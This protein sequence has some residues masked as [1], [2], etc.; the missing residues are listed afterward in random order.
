[1]DFYALDKPLIQCDYGFLVSVP[2]F[3]SISVN[4]PVI[5]LFD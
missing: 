5:H 4:G 3:P 2:T 1:M